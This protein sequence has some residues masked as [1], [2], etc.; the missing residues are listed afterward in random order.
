MSRRPQTVMCL[1]DELLDRIVLPW[2]DARGGIASSQSY[3]GKSPT[4]E[5]KPTSPM[6]QLCME[7]EAVGEGRLVAESAYRRLGL[8]RAG[9]SPFVT[10]EVADLFCLAADAVAEYSKLTHIAKSSGGAFDM[11]SAWAELHEPE[12]AADPAAIETLARKLLRFCDGIRQAYF[13][14]QDDELAEAA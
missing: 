5:P 4:D 14:A 13:E 12:L 11:V 6:Q 1:S 10:A 3:A 8:M 9:S 7:V 2:I